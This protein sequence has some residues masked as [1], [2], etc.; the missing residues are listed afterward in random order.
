M[1][2][3]KKEGFL[4]LVLHREPAW[5][6][7]LHNGRRVEKKEGRDGL[8]KKILW[9]P[10]V[11]W[12]EEEY[13][14]L[15]RLSKDDPPHAKSCPGCRFIEHLEGRTDI[16]D[17]ATILKFVGTGR[18][19]VREIMK[20][21][22]IG[23]GDTKRAYQ[24]SFVAKT[25]YVI[26]V[27]PLD[28]PTRIMLTN[29]KW[30]LGKQL[31]ARIKKDI[32]LYG[33]EDGDPS[34]VPVAYTFEYDDGT[35]TY[36]VSR[37]EKVK[38][39]EEIKALWE[40]PAPDAARFVSRGNPKRLLEAFTDAAEAA[41]MEFPLD[42][43]FEP[44]LKAWDDN[45]DQEESTSFNP[46]EIEEGA[47]PAVKKGANKA[48]KPPT[49]KPP[50]K[51]PVTKVEKDEPPEVEAESEEDVDPAPKKPTRGA[52]KP[53]ATKPVLVPPEEE[54]KIYECEVCKGDFPSN[55][56]VCPSCG[57][58]AFEEGEEPPPAAE[59]KTKPLGK[60]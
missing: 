14:K 49:R 1:D 19:E 10:F 29:E 21:D 20:V 48:E 36:G 44:A 55:V 3:W 26:P 16:A 41:E 30:S 5:V 47:K 38:I 22:F 51:V 12:E 60:F 4:K 8:E 17:D 59:K 7:N 15:R 9:F 54:V 40:A 28:D 43:I 6:R 24:D 50:K 58:E 27:I 32:K 2:S 56:N 23:L 11:C 35:Q 57:A 39:T 31:Y 53:P 42:A 45:E 13:H 33:E 25:D 37:L 46:D 18:G 34:K 52:K